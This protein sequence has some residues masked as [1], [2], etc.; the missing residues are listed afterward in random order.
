MF[1]EISLKI[2]ISLNDNSES[3]RNNLVKC[4]DKCLNLAKEK[5]NFLNIIMFYNLNNCIDIKIQHY[6]I[7]EICIQLVDDFFNK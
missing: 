3:N 1:A 7:I 4:K 5:I 2:L 6:N